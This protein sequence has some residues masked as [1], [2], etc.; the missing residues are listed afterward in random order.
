M[1]EFRADTREFSRCNA[2][3]RLDE[4]L[5]SAGPTSGRFAV[6]AGYY[7]VI[8]PAGH[9]HGGG[10]G[11]GRG[12]LNSH[13]VSWPLEPLLLTEGGEGGGEGVLAPLSRGYT[14]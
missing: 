12:V 10:G 3:L 7:G 9:E 14:V 6:Q 4:N 13:I 8:S 1:A 11:G 5:H 2:R